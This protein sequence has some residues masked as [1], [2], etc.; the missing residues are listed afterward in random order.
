MTAPIGMPNTTFHVDDISKLKRLAPLKR[1]LVVE[2]NVI[3]QK[4]MLGLLRSLE[5]SN[6]ELA[7]DGAQAISLVR[8][9]PAAFD[10]VLMDINMPLMDGHE[11][12]AQIRKSGNAI[13]IVAMTA[14]AL[15]GDREQCLGSGMNDYISKPINRDALAVLLMHWLPKN[16]IFENRIDA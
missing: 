10:L 1:L 11:A 13:P 15:K 4:V 9:A 8:S 5:F 16:R 12:T 6:V 14:Y 2:D 7:G 3:N